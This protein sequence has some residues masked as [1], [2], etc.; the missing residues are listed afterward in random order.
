MFDH[1][2]YFNTAALARRLD[3]E[4]AL[5]YKPF[6]LTT[7][8]GFMLRAVLARPGRL[9]SELADDLEIARPTA[10]RALDALQEKGLIHRQ[11]RSADGRQTAIAPTAS[12]IEMGRGLNEA[13][14]EVSRRLKH[15]LGEAGF[16]ETVLRVRDTRSALRA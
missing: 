2:L 1:C 15:V 3:R 5:A 11:V 13:S 9:P 6:G 12:A 16:A 4:W 10:T 14:A 8:Q 7:P